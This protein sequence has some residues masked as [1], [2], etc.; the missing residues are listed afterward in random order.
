LW[1]QAGW[2]GLYEMVPGFVFASLAIVV[3]SL[4]GRPPSPAM[5]ATYDAVAAELRHAGH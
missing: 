2:F 4:L 5:E 1:K 3:V